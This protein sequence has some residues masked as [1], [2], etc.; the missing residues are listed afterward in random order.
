MTV[1][2]PRL[3]SSQVTSAGS[4]PSSA[5]T[6][7]PARSRAA[8]TVCRA[9]AVAD[10]AADQ[11][12]RLG[13]PVPHRHAADHHPVE[14]GVQVGPRHEPRRSVLAAAKPRGPGEVPV[15]RRAGTRSAPSRARRGPPGP[16]C[17]RRGGGH[18]PRGSRLHHG[19]RARECP[20]ATRLTSAD[21]VSR[22]CS[23]LLSAS[24]AAG[25]RFVRCAARRCLVL[26]QLR[27]SPKNSDPARG[28]GPPCLACASIRAPCHQNRPG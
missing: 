26:A 28:P 22:P 10:V 16:K 11:C 3:S 20:P 21:P 12:E 1:A 15:P 9:H 25:G 13:Q 4:M 27:P 14:N 23:R 7:N 8:P 19:A 17:R 6:A 24:A 2:E 5:A 18:A